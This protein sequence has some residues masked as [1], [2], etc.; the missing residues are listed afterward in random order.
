MRKS[1]WA[2]PREKYLISMSSRSTTKNLQRVVA[3]LDLVRLGEEVEE[4]SGVREKKGK[5]RKGKERRERKNS[6]SAPPS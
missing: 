5:E 1:V 4:R 6:L 2:N 3:K